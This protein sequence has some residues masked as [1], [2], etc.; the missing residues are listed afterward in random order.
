MSNTSPPGV[1]A[2]LVKPYPDGANSMRTAGIVISNNN[3]TKLNNLNNSVGGK[4]RKRS[5]KRHVRKNKKNKKNN[6]SKK[7]KKTRVGGS[8]ITVPPVNA[9]YPETGVGNQTVAG[10]VTTTTSLGA[11]TT[12]NSVYD[13]CVGMSASACAQAGGK[14]KNRTN[15]RIAR[16]R[17]KTKKCVSFFGIF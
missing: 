12:A 4:L 6:N 8:T 15:K 5:N 14:K 9:S 7:N 17:K 10:N 16:H 2:P 3:N 11:T 1:T 13:K